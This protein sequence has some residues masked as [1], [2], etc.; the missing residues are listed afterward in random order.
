MHKILCNGRTQRRL[1]SPQRID[2]GQGK[3]RMVCSS[4]SATM[5]VARRPGFVILAKRTLP[6]GVSRSSRSSRV[7]PAPRRKPS[8]AFSGASAFGPFRSSTVVGLSAS[9]PST[10]SVRRRG[11][12]KAAA[13]AYVSPASTTPFVIAFFRSSAARACMRAGIS[14]E[15][16]SISR[17]GIRCRLVWGT[18]RPQ[19]FRHRLSR[20]NR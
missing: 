8:I 7:S 10:V 6:F 17:S 18:L 3:D 11:V 15:K 5:S 20:R 9:S 14:S 12:A 13:E 4:T 16:S 19:W 1:P 2:L